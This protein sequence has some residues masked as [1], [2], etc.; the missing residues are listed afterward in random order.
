MQFYDEVKITV[1]SGKW[2]NGIASGRR[3]PNIPHWW[4]NGGDGWRGGAIILCA[5]KDEDTLLEYKYK[6]SF[7]ADNGEDG[8]TK[9][10]YGA[11]A[12]NLT[13]I[14]PVETIIKDTDTGKIL[15]HF[16]R[17]GEKWTALEWGVW[18]KGNI[19]FKDAI[20][21]YPTM[22][23]LWEPGQKS[24][25]TLELQLLGDVWLIWNPSVGKS[26]LINCVSATKAKVADYPF[27]T[28]VPNLGSIVV[29]DF[30]FNMVDIPG[31][32]KGASEGKGLGNDFLRHV[33][34][35]RVFAM[36]MDM[37]RYEE[38]IDET[39]ELFDEMRYYI[40]DKFLA[41]VNE[42]HFAFEQEKE[43]W[44]NNSDLIAFNV[45]V[46]DEIFLSKKII[47][48]LN[49]YDLISDEEVKEEYIKQLVA[50]FATYLSD[51]QF[52]QISEHLIRDNIFVTSAGTMQ[53]VNEWKL[54]LASLLQ[55][56]PKQKMPEIEAF[57]S[58]IEDEEY[59]MIT[60]IT[61]IEKPRLIE[62]DY[63]EEIT[64]K[65]I[66]VFLIQNAEICRLTFIIP[67]WNDEAELRFWKQ[68]QQKW[69]I[70]L[71]EQEWLRKWD[72]LKIKSYYAGYDD[73]Y[74]V[75]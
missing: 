69:F 14:V 24:E 61:E 68:M 41:D 12:D 54:H 75:Y 34:K 72:V 16:T 73:R 4:P 21:Q 70:D 15:H 20:T 32:I 43:N 67:R 62:H 28:L 5:S 51:R 29:W 37:A 60:D 22:F 6:K 44:I 10:Q 18:G 52:D 3:A 30:R 26:S 35:S 56:L 48:T 23:L 74:V 50:K 57:H 53:W 33:L 42:Y 55:H 38:W 8:R 46:N 47:F 71:L 58:E 45:Y 25:I 9:D 65:Y 63:L 27:T 17:D 11:D 19:H 36:V 64:S 49:K 40:E 13:L 7:K 31:I 39:F 59:D 1:E 2:W 66:N